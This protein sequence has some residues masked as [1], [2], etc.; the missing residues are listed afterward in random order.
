MKITA[1]FD[2]KPATRYLT[3]LRIRFSKKTMPSIIRG[4]GIAILKSVIRK[5]KSAKVSKLAEVGKRKGYNNTT[6]G[7][8]KL[9]LNSGLRG[10]KKNLAWFRING[11]WV[12]GGL[13]D[14]NHD[15]NPINNTADRI[16]SFRK[17]FEN[18]KQKAKSESN[19]QKRTR[20][21]TAQNWLVGIEQLTEG[22]ENTTSDIRSYIKSAVRRDG[23]KPSVNTRKGFIGSHGNYKIIVDFNSS[24]ISKTG[25]EFKLRMAMLSRSSYWRRAISNGWVKDANFLKRT[26]P[27]ISVKNSI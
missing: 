5:Q 19:I 12:A 14:G 2:S 1:K 8:V 21:S 13:W 7:D 23:K 10:G 18:G 16:D 22:A 9:S 11:K 4:E 26:Y 25:G 24:I 20:G 27:S 6:V 3:D 17:L 15:I